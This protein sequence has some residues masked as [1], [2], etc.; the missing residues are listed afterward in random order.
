MR[1]RITIQAVEGLV[2]L[3]PTTRQP[4]GAEPVEVELTTYWR[5]RIAE[6][7][8]VVIEDLPEPRSEE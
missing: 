2:V 7:A 6:G 5:R 4:I 8:V 3:E 1:R